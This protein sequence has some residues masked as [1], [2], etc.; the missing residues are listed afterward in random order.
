MKGQQLVLQCP[1]SCLPV[2]ACGQCWESVQAAQDAGCTT[3]ARGIVTS[4]ASSVESAAD[5]LLSESVVYPNPSFDGVFTLENT[6]GFSGNIS[7]LD[8]S[9][10]QVA[11][12]RL[13]GE[14]V[15][16]FQSALPSGLFFM[17]LQSDQGVTATKR[18]VVIGQ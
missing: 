10:R 14:R 9:G 7:V 8:A 11:N 15:F 13:N 18:L 2:T 4:E 1:D 3:A 17:V 6:S 12:Y 16:R 5:I